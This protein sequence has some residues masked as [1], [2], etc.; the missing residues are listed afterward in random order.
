MRIETTMDEMRRQVADGDADRWGGE[1]YADWAQTFAY[2]GS[3]DVVVGAAC[4]GAPFG[5]SDVAI[6][7]GSVEGDNAGPDWVAVG[8]LRDGRF[9]RVS[10]G[11]DYTGWD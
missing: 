9:F 2:G 7:L 1:N 3:P 6:L 10:A 11:C 4:S 5:I 8:Q